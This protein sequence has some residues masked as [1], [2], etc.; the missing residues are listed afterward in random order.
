MPRMGR[1][2]TLLG[3]APGPHFSISHQVF[4][5]ELNRKQPDV[6]KVTKSCKHNLTT[7][8]GLVPAS[9]KVFSREYPPHKMFAM[10]GSLDKLLGVLKRLMGVGAGS[11]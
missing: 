9:R 4:M 10:G 2:A 7:Q 5:E 3:E 8:V 1:V 11:H 6:E